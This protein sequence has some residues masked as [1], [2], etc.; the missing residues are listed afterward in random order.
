M[1]NDAT[2][3]VGKPSAVPRTSSLGTPR[4]RDVIG[5]TNT[6]GEV[7]IERPIGPPDLAFTILQL[8][9]VNPAK[10]LTTPTGRPVKILSEGSFISELV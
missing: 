2:E 1:S 4:I 6:F 9:G 8:L 3:S 5:A 10:E 7:P